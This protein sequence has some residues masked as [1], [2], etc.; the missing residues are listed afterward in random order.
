M[1]SNPCIPGKCARGC[2]DIPEERQTSLFEYYWNLDS[3]RRKDWI[4]HCAHRTPIKR[5]KTN[6]NFSRRNMTYEYFINDS[7]GHKQVCQ[8]FLIDTLA[9]TQKI[10]I[11]PLEHAKED[12]AQED[13]EKP[14]V[15]KKY[16]EEAKVFTKNF[17]EQ[18]PAVPSHYNQQ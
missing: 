1:K 4:V 10:I 6:S 11:Y 14:N 18:L 13:V 17:I 9:I 3:Q 15:L 5:N 12:M 7:E 8:K 16:T 2:Y